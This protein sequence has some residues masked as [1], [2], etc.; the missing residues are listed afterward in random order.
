MK[1][2]RCTAIKFGSGRCAVL[3]ARGAAEFHAVCGR[4]GLAA[5]LDRMAEFALLKP[6][7]ESEIYTRAVDLK[8]HPCL[9][10]DLSSHRIVFA[11]R[12]LKAAISP[13][14]ET[15]QALLSAL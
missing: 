15:L 14:Y 4:Y 3:A 5:D 9:H 2:C 8:R 12:P 7:F 13:A 10:G 11:S 6:H 1:F